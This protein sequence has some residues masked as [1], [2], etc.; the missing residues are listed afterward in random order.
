MLVVPSGPTVVYVVALVV[1]LCVFCPPAGEGVVV[2]LFFVGVVVGG[3][4]V[5]EV[6]EAG[7]V[8]EVGVSGVV[9]G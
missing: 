5:G 3:V 2:G 4:G 6:G 1:E 7:E 8:G 9:V